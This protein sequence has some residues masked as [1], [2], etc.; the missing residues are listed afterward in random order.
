M[1]KHI[2]AGAIWIVAIVLSTAAV[3]A[4]VDWRPVDQAIGRKGADQPGGVHKYSF[5]RSDLHVMLDGVALR[6]A[7]ALGGWTAFESSGESPRLFFMH[8]WANADAQRLAR[9]LRAALGHA[10]VKRGT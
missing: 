4:P 7:L 1:M 9:G 10:N 3:A 6:P 5:P 8:F 2:A